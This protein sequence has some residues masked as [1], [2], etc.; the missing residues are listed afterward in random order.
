M[1]YALLDLPTRVDTAVA[2]AARAEAAGLDRY[3][4]AQVERADPIALSVPLASSW[5]D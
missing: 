5:R 2:N 3:S 4:V 1:K